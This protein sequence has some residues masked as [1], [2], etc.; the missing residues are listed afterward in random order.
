MLL[1]RLGARQVFAL[2]CLGAGTVSL[3]SACLST[4]TA[5]YLWHVQA[6]LGLDKLV[7]GIMTVMAYSMTMAMSVGPQAATNY[8]VLSSASHLIGFAIMPIVGHICDRVGYFALFEGLAMG[9]FLS[10]FIGDY[11]LRRR[12][13]YP[14]VA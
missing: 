13:S 11:L 3:L 12:L 8:A 9:A 5:P 6:V 1:R 4:T 10:I 7:I 2:G 14:E